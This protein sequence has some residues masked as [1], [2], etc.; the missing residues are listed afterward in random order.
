MKVIETI[1][2]EVTKEELIKMWEDTN[3]TLTIWGEKTISFEK[4]R[5]Y[6]FC[7]NLNDLKNA[8]DDFNERGIIDFIFTDK[9]KIEEREEN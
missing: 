9:V 7:M 4:W 5:D 2:I 3:E 1:Q 8:I 6:F